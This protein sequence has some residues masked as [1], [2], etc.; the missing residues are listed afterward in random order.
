MSRLSDPRPDGAAPG[1]V[2]ALLRGLWYYA[3]P[4][5]LLGRGKMLHRTLLG[6][7]V[8]IGRDH[9]GRVFALRD[10]C[11]HRGIPLSYGRLEGSEV[12]C[13]Y[14]GWRFDT[15]G[16]CTHI[17]SLVDGQKFEVSKIAV[18]GYPVH[19]AQGNVWIFMVALH[20]ISRRYVLVLFMPWILQTNLF[21]Q[22]QHKKCWWLE[23]KPCHELLTGPI[24]VPACYLRMVLAPSYWQQAVNPGFYPHLFILMAPIR[25]C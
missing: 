9:G 2:P 11:P 3:L 12:T 15:A 4:A 18:R 13:C 6:E 25:T 20:L 14:H 19:E 10:I 24:V 23:Q 16:R 1:A 17:P 21:V 5:R 7:P 8:L 22:G